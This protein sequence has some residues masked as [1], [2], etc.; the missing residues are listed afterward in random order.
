MKT[1]QITDAPLKLYGLEEVD[2]ENKRFFRMREEDSCKVSEAV[3]QLGIKSIGGRIRFRTNADA[4]IVKVTMLDGGMDIGS[5]EMCL[6]GV[7]VYT[8]TGPYA[9]Y[10]GFSVPTGG[11]DGPGRW[12]I[13]LQSQPAVPEMQ[14][15][16]INLPRERLE[17]VEI[18]FP[19]EAEVLP[20]VPYTMDGRIL[21][22][23]SSIT[24]GYCA[25]RPGNTYPAMLSRWLDCDYMNWGFAGAARG[26]L[27]L[28]ECIALREISAF[29]M[30]YDHNAPTAEHLATTHKP[31]YQVVRQAKPNIPIIIMSRPDFDSHKE[32]SKIYRDIIQQTYLDACTQGDEHVYFLDGETVY[33]FMDRGACTVDTTHPSDLGFYKITEQLYR[34]FQSRILSIR[35]HSKKYERM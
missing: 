25:S 3:H 19:D 12:R 4:I 33:G 13:P 9:I 26:E 24:N 21:F 6:G 32:Q 11:N 28:A 35:N 34:I 16:T 7:D 17:N 14:L 1:Y 10:R 15:V 27:A 22:Y 31:F 18:D 5:P 8:G 23:G 20:P 29:I 2:S 30:E